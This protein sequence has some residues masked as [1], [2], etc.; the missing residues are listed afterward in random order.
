MAHVLHG[1]LARAAARHPQRPAV[2]SQG[3]EL[4]Y[5]ELDQI[6]NK[7]A[8]ALLRMGVAP[9]DRVGILAPKSAAAAVAV[10][11]ALKAGACYV[12]LDPKAPATRISYVVQD[13]DINVVIADED[14]TSQVTDLADRGPSQL[15]RLTVTTCPAESPALSAE[16]AQPLDGERAIETDLAYMLYTSGSTGTPKGVMISHR[17]SLTFVDWSAAAAG[18]R[19]EDRIC[20]PAPLHFDLSVFDVFATCRAGACLT[21]IPDR[22]TTFPVSIA[23]WLEK[24]QVSIWYSV[25]SVLTLLACFGGLSTFDLSRL[26]TVIFAGEVFP[27]KYLAR[28]MTELPGPR[29]LNWYGPTETNVCT[30]F[31]VVPG[32]AD[33]GP[34]PIGTACANTEVFAVTS[35][36]G[37]VT[38]PGDEGE[39][40]VRGPSLMRGYWKRPDQT[41]EVLV[42]NPLMPDRDELVYR[43]GDLVTVDATGNYVYLGRRDAM[44]KIRGYR[45]ELG[46]VEAALYRHPSIAEAAVLPIPDEL[47]GSRLNAVVSVAG[48]PGL[49]REDV[50]DHCRRW[51]PSYMVPDVV[52]FRAALPRTSTGKVDRV[53]LATERMRKLADTH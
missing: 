14:R 21:V 53:A 46:E 19:C 33:R 43:T 47:L 18:L 39:L 48:T 51:L 36:G 10:Y 44:V 3:G 29:Y 52:E 38:H 12:P 5:T 35:E 41:R 24:E 50:I 40:H 26:R 1:L 11:G 6:S 45:V 25:P 31:E 32:H 13:A 34:V 28:L 15:G 16:S 9:G 23:Q 4:T 17:N 42:P 22:T 30:A 2:W 20:S 8:R 49:T 27:P 7:L 37:L